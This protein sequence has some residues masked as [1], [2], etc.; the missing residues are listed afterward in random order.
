MKITISTGPTF[1]VPAVRGGAVQRM[2]H[3]LAKEFA[4]RGHEVTVFARAFPD[5]PETE[6]R[7]GIRIVRWRGYDQGTDVRWDLVRC[8]WY[9]LRAASH[10]PEG[11]I[12]VTNDFWVPVFAARRK[13]KCGKVVI[14]A[15]R[16][17]KGQYGLYGAVDLVAAASRAVAQAIELQTP[18]LKNKIRVLPNSIDDYFLQDEDD[19][20][21]LRL[22]LRN[23]EEKKGQLTVLYVGRIHPEKGV[24]LL[25]EAW[26]RLDEIR[27]KMRIRT[28][29]RLKIIGPWRKEQGG[30]GVEYLESLKKK[31]EGV[32]WGEPVYGVEELAAV[33]DEGDI[34]VYPSVAEQGESF[35]LA[36]LEGMARGLPVVV[37]NLEVFREYLVPGRNGVSFEHRGVR[38]AENLAD[39]LAKLIED[40]SLR[41]AMSKEARATAEKY[42]PGNVADLYVQA[43]EDLL[44]N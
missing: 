12:L 39:A 43:F 17:P 38:A 28:D 44:K 6:N 10:L 41:Q 9:A 8:F 18:K 1:P 24:E 30:G 26:K 5:Q 4:K 36:P 33:Y 15:N 35:G 34:L 31:A 21:R 42:A 25:L 27:I 13:K 19:R 20:L 14:N 11:D 40:P 2:W 37:S 22:R 7:D 16:F 32:E 23:G 3:G 29:V